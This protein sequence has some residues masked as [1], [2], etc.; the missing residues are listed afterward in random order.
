MGQAA[1]LRAACP[2]LYLSQLSASGRSPALHSRPSGKR[3]IG[4]EKGGHAPSAL[5][6]PYGFLN[7]NASIP[8]SPGR[9]DRR[10]RRHRG[11][12]AGCPAKPRSPA[13]TAK[14]TRAAADSLRYS[15]KPPPFSRRANGCGCGA[16]PG[17]DGAWAQARKYPRQHLR[18][19]QAL[20]MC[21]A[22]G[23][24]QLRARGKTVSWGKPI[25]RC[26]R[27]EAS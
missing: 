7:N 12:S 17:C 21:R 19:I 2:P 11:D 26:A 8:P 24:R 22:Q 6:P 4:K 15:E 16:A 25:L 14:D 5:S 10:I 13:A 18:Q 3:A 9:Y 20:G 23:R 1:R 27:T